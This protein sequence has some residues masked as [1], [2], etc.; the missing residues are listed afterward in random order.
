M[1]YSV[2]ISCTHQVINQIEL[3]LQT[4]NTMLV[5]NSRMWAKKE[6]LN[7]DVAPPW[8]SMTHADTHGSNNKVFRVNG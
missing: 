5:V 3:E 8:P 7:F 4:H 1:K 6:S 2:I